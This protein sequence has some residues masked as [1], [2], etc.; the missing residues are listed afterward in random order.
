MVESAALDLFV[1][2][3]PTP[4]DVVR[5]ITEL[6]GRAQLPQVSSLKNT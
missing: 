5:Q 2:F 6:T 3:G 1:L 4:K